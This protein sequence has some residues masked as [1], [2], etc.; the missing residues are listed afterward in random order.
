MKVEA[1]QQSVP[2]PNIEHIIKSGFSMSDIKGLHRN[3]S[4][5]GV[6]AD[7]MQIKSENH[8]TPKMSKKNPSRPPR[9]GSLTRNVSQYDMD[10]HGK[11]I[12]ISI[13]ICT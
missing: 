9:K 5:D 11:E 1:D 8:L 7:E 6:E 13:Y 12:A 2:N 10:H 4:E 3:Y